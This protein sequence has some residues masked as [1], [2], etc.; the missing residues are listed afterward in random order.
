MGVPG[1]NEA[2]PFYAA[3]DAKTRMRII[4]WL[5]HV[6]FHGRR[7]YFGDVVQKE[8]SIAVAPDMRDWLSSGGDLTES[9]MPVIHRLRVERVRAWAPWTER[10]MYYEWYCGIDEL[11]RAVSLDARLEID[12]GY[13]KG[14]DG[15]W[16]R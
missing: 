10:P 12:H 15:Q 16:Y 6:R 5:V 8:L 1:P 9:V 3:M 13:H 11:G 4:D 14:E 2:D 7:G